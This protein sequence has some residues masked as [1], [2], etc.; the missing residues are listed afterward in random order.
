M[1]IGPLRSTQ[2]QAPFEV[3]R[4]CPHFSILPRLVFQTSGFG[5]AST[6]KSGVVCAMVFL[7]Q[8]PLED[9][10]A[11]RHSRPIIKHPCE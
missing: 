6:K 9:S 5:S 4:S 1:R 11:H 2:P 3:K 10:L 7:M 8:C